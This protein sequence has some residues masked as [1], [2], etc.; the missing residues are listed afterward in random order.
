MMRK[1]L[2]G[3]FVI[4]LNFTACESD[5]PEQVTLNP[6]E[7]RAEFSE[8]LES[9][10]DEGLALDPLNATAIGDHRF[11]AEFPDYLSKSYKDSSIAFYSRSIKQLA[12]KYDNQYLSG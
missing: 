11:N 3:L 10:Y 5:K 8:L 1:L 2:F 6:L 9:Y 12:E 4:S 7:V